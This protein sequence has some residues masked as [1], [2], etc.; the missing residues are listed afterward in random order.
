MK[1]NEPIKHIMSR[2]II[3]VDHN[4]TFS[5]AKNALEEH[6]IHHVP[7][8]EGAKLVGIISRFDILK[9]ASSEAYC[10]SSHQH[11][12]ALDHSITLDNIMTSSNNLIKINEHE[13][14]RDAVNILAREKFN[15]LPVVNDYNELV[16][17]VT[18]KDIIRYL[19]EQY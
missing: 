1:K 13:S 18:S 16:G 2:N 7:V 15:C 14:V 10:E 5:A 3:S 9:Y 12:A 19:L 17:M 11:D 4:G 6:D 8:L